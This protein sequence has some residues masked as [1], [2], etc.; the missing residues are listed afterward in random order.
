[1]SSRE[2]KSTNKNVFYFLNSLFYKN[3]FENLRAR[4]MIIIIPFI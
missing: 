2:I 3:I 4:Y 1:M